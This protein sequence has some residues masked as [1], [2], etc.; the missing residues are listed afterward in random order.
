VM[1]TPRVTP[2]K[3]TAA[4]TPCPNVIAVTVRDLGKK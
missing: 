3:R 4:D 2:V 1:D